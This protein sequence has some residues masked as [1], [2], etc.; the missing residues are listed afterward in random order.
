MRSR[1]P[2]T[3]G[4]GGGGGVVRTGN[5]VLG[6]YGSV[7]VLLRTDIFCISSFLMI[8]LKIKKIKNIHL[9]QSLF[10]AVNAPA[11]SEHP[12]DRVDLPAYFTRSVANTWGIGRNLST[13]IQ[14]L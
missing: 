9:L 13:S 2:G 7:P 11:E 4:G 5:S 12:A 6:L 1:R 14:M 10:Y 3:S 8:M